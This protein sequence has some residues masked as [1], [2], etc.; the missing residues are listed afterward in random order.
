MNMTE[1]RVI[2][3]VWGSAPMTATEADRRARVGNFHSRRDL[4]CPNS[5][6][7]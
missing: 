7:S 1:P 3:L 4:C 2:T 6:F 5:L